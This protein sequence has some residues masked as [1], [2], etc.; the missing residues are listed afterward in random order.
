[1]RRTELPEFSR[2][3][4]VH[5]VLFKNV[6][7]NC[8]PLAGKVSFIISDGFRANIKRAKK[9]PRIVHESHSFFSL[10]IDGNTYSD[11][12]KT[13]GNQSLLLKNLHSFAQKTVIFFHLKQL[14]DIALGPWEYF[15][16]FCVKYYTP[17]WTWG[18]LYYCPLL[19]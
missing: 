11:G 17:W 9:S 12:V 16:I 13:K 4:E 7:G 3:L 14:Q 2:G 8:K 6:V 1:M 19:P 5:Q 15:V 18:R 10:G